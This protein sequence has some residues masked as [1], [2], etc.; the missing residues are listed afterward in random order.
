[1]IIF[2][3][4]LHMQV[5]ITREFSLHSAKITFANNVGNISTLGSQ[6]T[7]IWNSVKE[8]GRRL[9][10][11]KLVKFEIHPSTNSHSYKL[12]SQ[13]LKSSGSGKNFLSIVHGAFGYKKDKWFGSCLSHTPKYCES[14]VEGFIYGR[15]FVDFI[16]L[17]GDTVCQSLHGVLRIKLVHL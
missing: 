6:I 10:W 13:A 5:L 9:R 17:L 1:M 12:H 16:S 14:D 3:D 4:I 11:C 2:T 8:L 15:D 7:T